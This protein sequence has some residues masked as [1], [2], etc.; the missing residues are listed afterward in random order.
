MNSFDAF[1]TPPSSEP[2][3]HGGRLNTA[4]AASA[5]AKSE[6]LDLS[7]ALNPT[8]Y[9]VPPITQSQWQCLPEDDD[10]LIDI[11]QQY[12]EQANILP[13]AGSQQAIQ[14]LATTANQSLRIGVLA[15]SYS[16][17][18]HCWQQAG[19][20]V[21]SLMPDQP[22]NDRVS[23]YQATINAVDWAIAELD[24]LIIVN[25]N[26][27]TGQHFS[28]E[29]LQR[30]QQ[31]LSRHGGFL[32][33]DEAFID[34]EPQLSLCAQ[35]LMK[36]TIILRSLG[37]FF[38]MAGARVGFLIGEK[39]LLQTIRY[40]QGPWPIATPCRVAASA[41]LADNNWQTEMREKLSEQSMRLKDFFATQ[42]ITSTGCAL[43][44]YAYHPA[45]EQIFH[46]LQQQA[47][48]ARFYPDYSALRF[49]IPAVKDTESFNKRFISALAS[50]NTTAISLE[51]IA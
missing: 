31:R 23:Y 34:A 51:R 5:I 45:A 6:W 12:Y 19:H 28:V 48:L 8:P 21:I 25:P 27:P 42:Q 32:L 49:A 20:R 26:N 15:H 41:A 13:V 4:V 18:A 36:N 33:V 40:A 39:S 38:G 7:A 47:V 10:G 9:P 30:W 17:H 11:A 29:Q 44:Q 43:F 16:E 2:P 24:I 46:A 50:V 1:W 22:M 3:L 37:K 14:L 35:P